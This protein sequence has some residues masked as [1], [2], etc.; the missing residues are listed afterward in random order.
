MLVGGADLDEYIWK[1]GDGNDK[2][3][4]T[5]APDVKIAGRISI[6]LAD[7]RSLVASNIFIET[8]NGSKVYKSPDGLL[9]LSV[10]QSTTLSIDGGGQIVLGDQS[11][12]FKN[13]D[14]GITL[15]SCSPKPAA[16]NA[17]LA[18]PRGLE[19]SPAISQIANSSPGTTSASNSYILGT[20]DAEVIA[21][22]SGRQVRAWS[23]HAGGGAGDDALSGDNNYYALLSIGPSS[24][25]TFSIVLLHLR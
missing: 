13:G 2:V 22:Q 18:F 11:G 25:L 9:T 17:A 24:L 20:D 6:R 8:A 14:F 12:L 19:K 3:L 1:A 23:R 10:G 21:G 15:T 4:E 16:A 5:R 7:G